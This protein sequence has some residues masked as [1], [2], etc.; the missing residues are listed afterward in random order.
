MKKF[1]LALCAM[2]VVSLTGCKKDPVT[3]TPGSNSPAQQYDTRE[4]A[5]D[6]VGK[7]TSVIFSDETAPEVWSWDR[8]TGRLMSVN[9]D[10]MCGGYIERVVFSYLP[11]GRVD[12]VNLKNIQLGGLLPGD[13]ISGTMSVG[14]SGEY[15]SSLSVVNN[16][17]D[18]LSV[19]VQRNNGNKIG[20]AT[21]DLSDNMLLD[22]FNT[23]LAQF[24]P[25]SMATGDLATSVD[26]VTGGASLV[27]EG[28]NVRQVLLNIGFRVTTTIGTLINVIGEDN[29][30][31]LGTAGQFLTML[32]AS[33]PLFFD[34]A[35]GDTVDYTYDDKVNPYRNYLG[36]LDVSALTANNVVSA[37]HNG[38]ANV[39]IS[40]T[41]MGSNTQFYQTSYPLPLESTFND[42]LE[43]NAAG[44]PLRVED[45]NGVERQYQ[46]ME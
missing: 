12:R 11:D 21:I 20:G 13:G 28:D 9:D 24:I 17:V 27:W 14:Y 18:V 2:V 40:T 33:Q 29:L 46:Y 31:I 30:G 36:R 26:N 6:P 43:Y 42:Y 22:L 5:Y 15:I 38:A 37:V 23:M 35:V 10:D 44:C 41:F 3:P 19:Q 1:F 45:G 16:G 4:G 8:E 32:P 34:V 7:I 25:D 39:A